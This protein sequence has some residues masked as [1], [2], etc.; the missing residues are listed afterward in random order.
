M[1]PIQMKEKN[2]FIRKNIHESSDPTQSQLIVCAPCNDGSDY[3]WVT[4]VGVNEAIIPF[5]AWFVDN[6]IPHVFE[7]SWGNPWLEEDWGQ[8]NHDPGHTFSI[9][10]IVRAN[11][12][13]MTKEE[14]IIFE[15]KF[16]NKFPITNLGPYIEQGMKKIGEAEGEQERK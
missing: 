16:L 5:K 7:M 3:E 9:N 6:D 4:E 11:K 2:N 1:I 14:R 15:L 12:R 10:V 8:T 13:P